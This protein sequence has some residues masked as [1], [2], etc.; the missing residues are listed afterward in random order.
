M[1]NKTIKD[2]SILILPEFG[3]INMNGRMYDPLLGR[4]LSPDPFVQMPDFSQSFNRYSYCLNNPLK[5]NDP[6]GNKWGWWAALADVLT[7]G[8]VSTTALFTAGAAS[9]LGIGMAGVATTIPATPGIISSTAFAA[10]VSSFTV[11][12]AVGSIGLGNGVGN[13]ALAA[14]GSIW[15]GNLGKRAGNAWKLSLGMFKTD[16]SL[17][18]FQ[19]YWQ[20]MSRYTYE[21]PVTAFGQAWHGVA[22]AFSPGEV[23]VGFFHGATVL[24][25]K[26]MNRDGVT[27]GSNITIVP[28][29]DGNGGINADNMTLLH[30]Y[31]HYLQIRRFGNMS[32]YNMAFSS[33]TT[34]EGRHMENWAEQDANYRSMR[35]FQNKITPTQYDRFSLKYAA[36]SKSYS[37]RLGLGYIMPFEFFTSYF[38]R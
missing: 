36:N 34:P 18:F 3:L 16:E 9:S 15:G 32:W 20:F 13:T 23:N 6:S 17:N 37:Y 33:S 12:G 35:Y 28:D 31:G 21:M 19:R 38:W 29:I 30:E 11:A 10:G 14:I 2:S 5:Y 26:W 7:G 24:Q 22:N 25:A 27:V 8:A 4:F 1:E